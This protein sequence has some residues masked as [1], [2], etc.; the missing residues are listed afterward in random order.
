[1][2]TKSTWLVVGM[3]L[4]LTLAITGI[5]VASNNENQEE[6][7]SI[8]LKI[9]GQV[10]EVE[11]YTEDG[12]A[13][14]DSQFMTDEDGEDSENVYVP[15]RKLFEELGAKVD[16]DS[17]S[18]T[19]IIELP[20][21]QDFGSN[22]NHDDMKAKDI[23]LKAEE[24]MIEQNSYRMQGEGIIS[25]DFSISDMPE[26]ASAET[27]P[28]LQYPITMEAGY[29]YDP[30]IMHITQKLE[31]PGVG[32]EFEGEIESDLEDGLE[33]IENIDEI[34]EIDMGVRG[35]EEMLI[36]ED[37]VFQRINED[38]WVVNDFD[39]QGIADTMQYL[40]NLDPSTSLELAE[41]L[42]ISYQLEGVEE[43]EGEDYYVLYLDINQD[44][45]GEMIEQYFINYENDEEME[46]LI[47]EM[48]ENLQLNM[49]Q[50]WYIHHE[51]FE[52]SHV[53]TNM[54]YGI[55]FVE[56]MEEQEMEMSFDTTIEMEMSFY[57]YG[58][59]IDFPEIEDPVA[60][61]DYLEKILE[62]IEQIEQI[63]E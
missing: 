12:T 47:D 29:S 50:Y 52:T 1:M 44:A 57:D 54:N 55:D 14:V 2:K 40:I 45:F 20:E 8:G 43:L 48:M 36:T 38:I 7:Q 37:G 51:T 17:E 53:T 30:F 39:E 25:V 18:R 60:W 6:D 11:M 13:Y 28:K 35:Q 19:I 4:L 16:W 41:D 5:G 42:G 56:K 61:D 58:E 22:N 33:E 21:D 27:L 34:D 63:Q 3:A 46:E 24:F 9:D 59:E 31:L 15:V 62:E 10:V 26:I 32:S 23:A 49:E